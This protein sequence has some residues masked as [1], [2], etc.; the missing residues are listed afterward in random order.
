MKCTNY[1]ILSFRYTFLLR[2]CKDS[3]GKETLCELVG[4]HIYG[5]TYVLDQLKLT[6][7]MLSKVGNNVFY[8]Q[9]I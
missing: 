1:Q 9:Y 2:D 4:Q 7:K 8:M 6:Q 3:K 5:S